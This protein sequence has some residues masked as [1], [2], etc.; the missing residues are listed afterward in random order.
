MGLNISAAP[1]TDPLRVRNIN[2]TCE[3][4]ST[5]FGRY[6]RPPVS[7][8]VC[9]LPLRQPS[10]ERT[11]AG[12]FSAKEIRGGRAGRSGG[13]YGMGIRANM[14]R[15]AEKREITEG[16]VGPECSRQKRR[17]SVLEG[18]GS[19]IANRCNALSVSAS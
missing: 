7:E 5:G 11:T 8:T 9:N 13:K 18:P 1:S 6:N 10:E 2:L 14:E 19:S 3:P 15:K 16:P 12:V 17:Q 4:W